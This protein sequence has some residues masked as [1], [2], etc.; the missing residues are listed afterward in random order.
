MSRDAGRPQAGLERLVFVALLAIAVDAVLIQTVIPTG[1][2]LKNVV[3]AGALGLAVLGLLTRGVV[4]P[5]WIVG[6]VA[7]LAGLTVLRHNPDQLSYIFVLVLAPA[8]WSIPERRVERV[9][10]ICSLVSLALVFAFLAAGVTHNEVLTY[11]GRA[12]YGTRGVPFFFNLVYGACAMAVLYAVKHQLRRRR[13]VVVAALA[14]AVYFYRQTD[15][16][17]GFFAFLAFLALL[18]ATPRLARSG[19]FRGVVGLLPPLF[20]AV[21]LVG[22]RYSGNTAL[23]DLTSHRLI[24][25]H[26]FLGNVGWSDVLLSSSVK[27]FDALIPVGTLVST[28]T[29]VDNSYLHLLVGGGVLVCAVFFVL[30]RRAVAA[31]FASGQ[32]VEVAFL[33]ATSLY[34]TTESILVR[35]ENVFVV[36]AWYLVLRYSRSDVGFETEAA[37]ESSRGP[38]E[39]ARR[40]DA[41]RQPGGF[42]GQARRRHTAV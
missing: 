26:A 16:R 37:D 19:L 21:A 8:L 32:H 33:V 40:R 23:N 17:G 34:F 41:A 38:G 7:V 12:T 35:I 5:G 36:Y 20:L 4:I 1:S 25:Y 11:R 9:V 2:S 39:R 22:S 13:G 15:V 42:R 24:T 27:H 18:W 28:A 31:L 6:L 29:S 14:V 10:V 30:W 3:R